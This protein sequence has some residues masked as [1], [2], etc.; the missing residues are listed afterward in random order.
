MVDR[1]QSEFNDSIGLLKRINIQLF[2]CWK[3]RTEK[4][5]AL[6][7]DSLNSLSLEICN[8]IKEPEMKAFEDFIVKH[9]NEIRTIANQNA[10]TGNM[11]IPFNLFMELRRWEIKFRNVYNESGLESKK[12]E[13]IFDDDEEW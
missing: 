2:Y 10:K 7:F 12:K 3:A 5:V 8:Y 1:E 11:L 9:Q 4:N 6:W 13:D